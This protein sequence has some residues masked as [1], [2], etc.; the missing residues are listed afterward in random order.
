MKKI[1]II[2]TR[3][4]L[5]Y[6]RKCYI[7]TLRNRITIQQ[8][9]EHEYIGELHLEDDEPTT[10]S[11]S[12]FDFDFEI[13]DLSISD[14]RKLIYE[15]IMLYHSKKAQKKYLSN[16]K[17]YPSGLLHQFINENKDETDSSKKC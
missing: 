11:V 4:Q 14:H 13:Y 17:K 12:A 1:S 16:K 6:S 5:I 2:E 9:L 7:T 8:A 15:E 3:L 10:V